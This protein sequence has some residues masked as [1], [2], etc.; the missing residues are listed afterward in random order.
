MLNKSFLK[1]KSAVFIG[2]TLMLDNCLKIALG[3]FKKI[4]VISED[5]KIYKKYKKKLNFIK[6]NNLNNISFD[7]MF[8]VLNKKIISKKILKNIKILKLNFHDGPLPKYAGLYSSSWAIVNKEKKHGVCWHKIEKGIDTG[9][10]IAENKFPIKNSDTSYDVDIKGIL[11]GI[12]L[13]QKIIQQLNNDKIKF[14]KQNLSQRS[15][16]GAQHLKKFYKKYKG[17]DKKPNIIRAFKLSVEKEKQLIKILKINSLKIRLIK[18]NKS[19]LKTHYNSIQYENKIYEIYQI[20]KKT[21][22][23]K[24]GLPSIKKK[25]IKFIE[26][27][28]LGAHS[29]WDSLGHIKFLFNVEKNYKIKINED[30]AHNF[31]NVK[32]IVNYLKKFT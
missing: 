16:Y 30:N 11:L 14:K 2:S 24:I 28:G 31:N 4:S 15:Y 8:S 26:N 18:D 12:K 6:I 17:F 27:L 19:N 9:D 7:Y 13:F 22:G 5:K 29:N 25:R 21:F 23:K 1:N 32:S 20:I 10:I 3:K